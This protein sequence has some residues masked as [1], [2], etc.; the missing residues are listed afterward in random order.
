MGAAYPPKGGYFSPFSRI[1]AAAPPQGPGPYKVAPSYLVCSSTLPWCHLVCSSTLPWCP[2]RLLSHS[3]RSKRRWSREKTYRPQL[4]PVRDPERDSDLLLVP[5]G[6][7]RP[8]LAKPLR[9]RYAPFGLP[10]LLAGCPLRRWAPFLSFG[11]ATRRP[12]TA[13]GGGIAPWP[14]PAGAP[15]TAPS[16]R[17]GTKL[18][19]PCTQGLHSASV[20]YRPLLAAAALC[21]P[22]APAPPSRAARPLTSLTS[23]PVSKIFPSTPRGRV[24][25]WWVTSSTRFVSF[26]I[27]VLLPTAKTTVRFRT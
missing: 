5:F 6:P 12:T 18:Q 1:K 2:S 8:V 13:W 4:T 24:G 27:I 25:L 20:S 11:Q 14:P 9:G 17:R 26:A 23:S 22:I 16:A 19:T 15:R 21:S 3:R 7:L 10:C